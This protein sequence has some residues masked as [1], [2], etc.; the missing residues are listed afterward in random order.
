MKA[1]EFNEIWHSIAQEQLLKS[2]FIRIGNTYIALSGT[3][4]L[5]F[6]K[7]TQKTNFHGFMYGYTHTFFPKWA[8]E[9]PSKWPLNWE[10]LMLVFSQENLKECAQKGLE[11]RAVLALDYSNGKRNLLEDFLMI[12]LEDWSEARITE[13]VSESVAL[14]QNEGLRIL[15]DLNPS[16]SANILKGNVKD[17]YMPQIWLNLLRENGA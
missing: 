2:G 8:E 4:L 11:K 12:D 17:T 16:V 13:Y 15:Y 3:T 1:Q 10:E 9:Y 5:Q 7:Q 14:A 6:S